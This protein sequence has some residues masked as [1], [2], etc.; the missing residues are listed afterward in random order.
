MALRSRSRLLLPTDSPLA[1]TIVGTYAEFLALSA[2]SLPDGVSFTVPEKGMTWTVFAGAWVLTHA[3]AVESA[4]VPTSPVNGQ[5]WKYVADATAGIVWEFEYRAASASAYK[6]EAVGSGLPILSVSATNHGKTLSTTYTNTPDG[7]ALPSLTVPLAG[8]Y[9][10]EVFSA[11]FMLDA[12]GVAGQRGYL[13][14]AVGASAAL[15]T[16][17]IQSYGASGDQG[18]S[19]NK[20]QRNRKTGLA[21]ATVLQMG[22]RTQHG[23]AYV[24]PNNNSAVP[25]GLRAIPV[26]VA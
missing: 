12:S 6:W 17:A 16:D 3:R 24:Y 26:R 4:T 11:D 10:V 9:D 8:D 23:G 21:A 19:G 13:S 7:G 20:T 15:D 2:A 18:D 1:G 14:Y 25:L 5:R 22:V